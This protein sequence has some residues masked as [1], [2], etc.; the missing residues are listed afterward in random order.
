MVIPAMIADVDPV[1]V[2]V[3]HDERATL[4]VGDGTSP[5]MGGVRGHRRT[6]ID[7]V[8]SCAAGHSRAFADPTR[9]YRRLLADD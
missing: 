5:D 8:C 6:P 1:E 2:V 9:Y 4:R 3:A 7:R